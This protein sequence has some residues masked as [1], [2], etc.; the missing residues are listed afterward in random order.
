VWSTNLDV[1]AYNRRLD[2]HAQRGVEEEALLQQGRRVEKRRV[3]VALQPLL[4]LVLDLLA[5]I[6]III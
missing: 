6:Y 4:Q 5:C 3:L 1:V 2:E